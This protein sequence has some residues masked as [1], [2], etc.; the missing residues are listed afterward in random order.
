MFNQIITFKLN[1]LRYYEKK[2]I[3]QYIGRYIYIILLEEL[4]YYYN[5]I[6]YILLFLKTC[7]RVPNI[8]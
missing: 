1:F 2:N 7:L 3:D 4:L 8:Q 6:I 5:M